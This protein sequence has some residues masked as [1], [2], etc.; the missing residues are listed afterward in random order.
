MSVRVAQVASLPACSGLT[1]SGDPPGSSDTFP[2]FEFI[3][4]PSSV[5]LSLLN[6]LIFVKAARVIGDDTVI[7]PVVAFP[8]MIDVAVTKSN[9]ASDR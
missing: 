4:P 1:A 3:L 8:M 6:K 7:S 9:S 2:P 5:T